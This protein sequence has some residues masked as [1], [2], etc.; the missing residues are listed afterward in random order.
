MDDGVTEE[1][2]LGT[3]PDLE[4]TA[5]ALVK[6]KEAGMKEVI[7]YS[8]VDPGEMDLPITKRRSRIG[9]FTLAGVFFGVLFGLFLSAGTALLYPIETGGMP[10]LSLPA[11][12]LMTFEMMILFSLLATFAGFLY[13]AILSPNRRRFVPDRVSRDRFGISVRGNQKELESASEILV[14]CGADRVRRQIAGL[15]LGVSMVFILPSL[16]MGWPWSQ[17]MVDQPARDPQE[18]TI[19]ILPTIVP[20]NGRSIE[21]ASK[22]EAPGVENPIPVTETS[23]RIGKK[24]FETFCVLCH[25]RGGKG[26][27]IISKKIGEFPDLSE[28]GYRDQPDGCFFV[29]MTNGVNFL[30]E[31]SRPRSTGKPVSAEDEPHA[32]DEEEDHAHDEAASSDHEHEDEGEHDMVASA[33]HEHEDEHEHE[34]TEHQ[35]DE[36]AAD[37]HEHEDEHAHAE[38]E[39]EREVLD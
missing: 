11:I 37:D 22:E 13:C 26:D 7:L 17:D 35:H 8:P 36:A 24:L 34:Q 32:H 9:R 4:E 19:S 14:R 12:G 5:Q 18:E 23:I 39:A 1:G 25:G 6:L 30:S 10:I 31:I 15:W 27:G 2:I 28:K 16:V 21:I 33:D 3:F 20:R 29:A 38:K